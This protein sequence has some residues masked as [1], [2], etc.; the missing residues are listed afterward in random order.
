VWGLLERREVR[1]LKIRL[2]LDVFV[3]AITHI[4]IIAT[5]SRLTLFGIAYD[6]S[7]PRELNLY[8]TNMTIE[9]YTAMQ[10]IRGT[11]DGR[12]FMRGADREMYEVT[13]SN[14]EG[15]WGGWFA[16]GGKVNVVAH[17]KGRLS[18]WTPSWGSGGECRRVLS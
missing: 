4:L 18:N 17:T 14:A 6:P 11:D 7:K 5:A 15:G 1:F 8:N 12:V 16:G 13:Y 9:T 3:D 2:T 10:D